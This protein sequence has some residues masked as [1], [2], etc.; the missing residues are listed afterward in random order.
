MLVP[1]Q[2]SLG[3]TIAKAIAVMINGIFSTLGGKSANERKL[4]IV[5]NNIANASTAGFKVSRSVF[6]NVNGEEQP[7]VEQTQAVHVKVSDSYIHFSD[8]PI[9][10]TGGTYDVGIEGG[11]F[12]AVSTPN[13]TMYTRNGQF[14]LNSDKKLV[15]QSGFPVQGEGGGE[16][17][18]DGKEVTIE[19]DGR[20][21]LIRPRRAR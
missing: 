11:G 3:T 13:G 15:T 16:I 21:M 4:E 10:A 2:F 5:S 18:I 20:Y 17:T 1:K 9:V 14:T 19:T 12:F 8:A 7:D 6:D